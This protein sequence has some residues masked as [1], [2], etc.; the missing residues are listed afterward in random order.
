MFRVWFCPACGKMVRE[1]NLTDL[2]LAQEVEARDVIVVDY[3]SKER[4]QQIA[5]NRSK[6]K[7]QLDKK[8]SKKK[9]KKKH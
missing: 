7:K 3:V 5:K 6:K 4:E 9:Y 2:G 8:Q 1:D